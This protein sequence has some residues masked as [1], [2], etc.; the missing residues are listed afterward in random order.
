MIPIDFID[1]KTSFLISIFI[2]LGSNQISLSGTYF[3][4]SLGGNGAPC[5][6]FKGD[7]ILKDKVSPLSSLNVL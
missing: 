2:G 5:V 1:L 4:R 6:T 3:G 7:F